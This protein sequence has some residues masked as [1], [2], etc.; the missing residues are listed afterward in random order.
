MCDTTLYFCIIRDRKHSDLVLYMRK[1]K[2]N[3]SL[4]SS[5]SLTN[6]ALSRLP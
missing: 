3:F 6:F 2:A 1:M 5:T 4:N